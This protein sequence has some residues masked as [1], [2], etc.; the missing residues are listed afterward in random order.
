MKFRGGGLTVVELEWLPDL[1]VGDEERLDRE[2][3]AERFGQDADDG[4]V[5][6]VEPN[7]AA[8]DRWVAA[9]VDASRGCAT[10]STTCGSAL[11]FPPLEESGAR[12]WDPTP[13]SV[14]KF[15]ETGVTSTRS[16]SLPSAARSAPV[17]PTSC[18][19]VAGGERLEQP[20]PLLVVTKVAWRDGRQRLIAD[21]EV[22]PDVG[23]PSGIAVRAAASSARRGRR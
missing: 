6:A 3:Q 7:L 10:G 19:P 9:V 8:D 4:M 20:A 11:V 13:S 14:K 2:E 23:E 1:R 15:A 16:V 21:A 22:D 5:E 18:A 12:G 17:A